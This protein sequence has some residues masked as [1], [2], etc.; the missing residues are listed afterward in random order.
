MR[1]L[2]CWAWKPVCV[3]AGHKPTAGTARNYNG[4]FVVCMICERCYKV[5]TI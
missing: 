5:L 4:Q 3:W 2:K 1:P